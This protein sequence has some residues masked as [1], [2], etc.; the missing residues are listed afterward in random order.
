MAAPYT[1]SHLTTTHSRSPYQPP[2]KP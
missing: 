2:R 1:G